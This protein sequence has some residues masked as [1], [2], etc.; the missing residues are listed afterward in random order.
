MSLHTPPIARAQML[1]RKP[2]TEVFEA[3]VNPAV[4]TRFWFTRSTA[5]LEPGAH[6]RWDWEMYGA[7]A[8][9]D[10]KAVDVNQ[11]ILV[12]WSGGGDAPTEVEWTFAARADGTTLVVVTNSGFHGTD[13]EQ[14]SQAIDA[15]GGFTSMLAAA[16]AL[17]EHG[18]E[19]NL[20]A[21]HH[22][23]AHVQSRE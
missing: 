6:V 4:T 11:R 19:L 21:D 2:V 12:H 23:D 16:K 3:F 17:L 15:M 18:I 1:L 22:P 5:R 10:V 20:V 7:S 14:V 8:D 9:V 13:D